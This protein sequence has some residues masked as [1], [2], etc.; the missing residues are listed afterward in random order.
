[1]QIIESRTVAHRETCLQRN[2]FWP[3]FEHK[4][5]EGTGET[6]LTSPPADIFAISCHNQQVFFFFLANIFKTELEP[7][8]D[9]RLHV[10]AQ[11]QWKKTSPTPL[12][13]IYFSIP[14]NSADPDFPADSGPVFTRV[15]AAACVCVKGGWRWDRKTAKA[16]VLK[17]V[18][19]PG[20]HFPSLWLCV[21]FCLHKRNSLFP[22]FGNLKKQKQ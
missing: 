3:I 22:F 10:C 13:F 21:S 17:F 19:L 20:F 9:F 15:R 14:D 18:C 8:W 4:R 16:H 1:M 2:E 11:T 5:T 12:P 7:L 6:P